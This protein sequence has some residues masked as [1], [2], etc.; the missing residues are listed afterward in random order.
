MANN[1]TLVPE[2][3]NIDINMFLNKYQDAEN[4]DEYQ[5]NIFQLTSPYSDLDDISSN[6]VKPFHDKEANCTCTALHLNI[7]SLPAKIDNLKLMISDLREKHIVIDFILLCETFLTEYNSHQ[8]NI[9]GY[10]FVYKNRINS[11]RGGVAIYI[12]DKHAFKMRDDLA[13]NVTGIFESV[14]IEVY[15]DHLKAV[16]G[17]IYRVPNSNEINSIN[18]YEN[19]IRKLHNYKNDIIIGTD[20]NFDYI[21][22]DHNKNTQY[23]FDTFVT[24][25]FF[26]TITKPTRITHTT[27]TLI[28]NIYISTKRKPNIH[29]AI[30]TIDI[31]D[32]L[33][34]ITTIGC[35]TSKIKTKPKTI[36]SRKISESG[37][38][39]ICNIIKNTDWQYLEQMNTNEAYITF[40]NK[41]SDIIDIETQ[42]KTIVIPAS[43]IIR[44]P[45]MTTGL[46]ASSHELNKLYKKKIGKDKTHSFSV[47]FHQYRNT[48]NKLKRTTKAIYY[49]ELFTKYKHDIRKTWGAI[50]SL[51][52]RTKDKTGISDTFKINN[53]QISD[54]QTISNEFC[55]F[56]TN[57]GKQYANDIPPSKFTF[58]QFMRNK[59]QQ[60]MFLAPTD[61]YEVSKLIESLKSKNSSGHDGITPTL[62]K[63]IK[64][65]ISHPVTILINK[66][67][68]TGIVPESLKIAKVIPIYKAKD[69]EQLNNYRPISLLPTISKILE[70]IIHKRLY[71]FLLTQSIFYPSQY[72][73]R[74][75]HST[76][77][78]IHEFVDETITSFE[79]KKTTLGVFLDLS[80]A[81]DTI[82]HGI[83]LKKLEWYGVRGMALEWFRSYLSNRKQFVQY[84]E[85]KSST[86][87]IPCGVPQGSVLGP[88]LFIVYTNDLPNCLTHS[89]AILFAD[90]TTI[91]FTSDDIPI[92]FKYVNFDLESL[93]EWFRAN[94]LSL[95]I[96]KT[97][98]VIFRTNS[99]PLVKDLNIKIGNEVIERKSVIKFLGVYIDEKLEWHDHINYIKNKLNSSLYALRKVKNILKTNHLI[100]LYYSLIYPYIDYGISL[101]GST[102]STHI[103]KIFIKQKKAIR[104]VTRA[105]Y[106][107]HTSP[108]FKKLN[109]IKLHDIYI[110]QVAKYMYNFSQQT[111]PL[112][113]THIITFNEDI[114]T[115]DTR[116]RNNPHIS[117]RRVSIASN[118]LRHKGPEIWYSIPHEI[119]SMK[120]I[121]SFSKRLK[122]QL[123]DKY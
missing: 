40:T 51:I 18:M 66:S 112:P 10:N 101:W 111:L 73:F 74:P 45:W 62:I 106:N 20:Q 56:F 49:D 121:K 110:L 69:K 90:D 104:I 43:R 84:K 77:Q 7:H 105:E 1:N 71:N 68:S 48:Y 83:L 37:K 119:H 85:S 32:H 22:I 27:A 2:D 12:N 79:N 60:N 63:D 100:T 3:S 38:T 11:N 116:N 54:P 9:P 17:E 80:K 93:S 13:T 53:K 82:D 122:K 70:K 26:P 88:L 95:N 72:G 67:L 87:T 29:S 107:A 117:Q 92:L 89:K 76:T 34:V 30:L 98:Y 61:P 65:E 35:N 44:D 4:P 113:L 42:E 24:N 47:K 57:I 21:K 39:K 75:K 55:N 91:S 97:N 19:I 103:N 31:S 81:F 52:G 33:P 86:H 41:L 108:L 102:H 123:V 25:G 8:F 96:G 5:P 94:K 109:I 46:I 118:C 6:I 99:K 36:R 115:H 15:S 28:D 23:L 78:A 114:H 120:T 64:Y 50:N 59:S 58:D 14:F 16:V